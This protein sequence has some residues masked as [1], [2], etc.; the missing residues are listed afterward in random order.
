MCSSILPLFPGKHFRYT[1]ELPA[2][3][4]YMASMCLSGT[5]ISRA[6]SLSSAFAEDIVPRLLAMRYAASLPA[7]AADAVSQPQPA[8]QEDAARAD[9]PASASGDKGFARP[10]WDSTSATAAGSPSRSRWHT[11]LSSSMDKLR[12]LTSG[13]AQSRPAADPS[14]G[15]TQQD[16]AEPVQG[17]QH[18]AALEQP[19]PQQQGLQGG[20]L[21]PYVPS[22]APARYLPTYVPFGGQHHLY[23][24]A[25]ASAATPLLSRAVRSAET[26]E[27]E[28]AEALAAL[29]SQ[30]DSVPGPQA[31]AGPEEHQRASSYL[32]SKG[33]R[34]QPEV[35]AASRPGTPPGLPPGTAQ[36]EAETTYGARRYTLPLTTYHRMYTMRERAAAI[37]SAAWS[38]DKHRSRPAVQLC[39]DLAPSMLMTGA[40]AQMPILQP[41]PVQPSASYR[42]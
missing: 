37:C 31:P 16:I 23:A 24:P 39:Q 14:D 2:H 38:T 15:S 33:R 13:T 9:M 8:A 42:R 11:S 21:R 4:L 41:L 40:T 18:A 17:E 6:L 12:A 29:E 5:A 3:G 19:A 32:S 26:F 10:S 36:V 34:E 30:K 28:D 7:A 20:A 27:A 25:T 35:Q 22:W 1:Y